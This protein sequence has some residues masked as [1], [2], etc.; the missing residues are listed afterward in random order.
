[1]RL[2]K[3]RSM[4]SKR[5]IE[6]L[7]ILNPQNIRYLSNFS[8]SVA[9]M[10][11]TMK[12]S[13]LLVDFCYLEQARHEVKGGSD[14][15]LVESNFFD[16]L[17]LTLD[18]LNLK[19]V[20][21]ESEHLTYDKYVN[22]YENLKDFK[23]MPT[24]GFVEILRSIK[25]KE[26]IEKISKA[27]HISD[28]VFKEVFGL[29]KPGIAEVE[30]ATEIEYLMRKFGAEKA[31]FETI[32][33]SGSN[34]AMPHARPTERKLKKGDL[35][36]IDLGAVYKGYCSDMTRMIVLGQP[37]REKQ[38]IY[39]L[40]LSA[41]EAALSEARSGIS[42]GEL[43]G[44]A[45][46]IIADEGYSDNFGHNLGH[47]VGLEAHEYPTLGPNCDDLLKNGMVFTVEPGIYFKD[48][49]GVRIE[50]LVVLQD[51]GLE[52][53]TKSPKELMVL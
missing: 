5:G 32:V 27:A 18:G 52:V 34:S 23:L 46:K 49:G 51:D 35:V 43:D 14:I 12:D 28:Q 50:D 30:I 11:V 37:D 19:R 22:L 42:C 39:N 53:L 4:I 47:G 33:A 6:A 44:I 26:E 24:R 7:L 36:K 9:L 40:V 13:L 17:R 21:F 29:I 41:Q 16:E 15:K 20:G 8:G 10:L 48:F 3:L 45:R 1:M 25:D 2:Q 31:S 38:K